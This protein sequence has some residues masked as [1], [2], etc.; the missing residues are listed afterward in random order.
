MKTEGRPP[1]STTREYPDRPIVGVGAV[2]VDQ[3]RVLLVKR[4]S[5]PLLGE[6][7]LPGGVVELGE[8]LRAAAEREAL[9]ETG[10]TVKAGEVL[11]VLDRIIPG[12]DTAPQ[13]HYVLIDFL[14]AVQGGELRAGGDAADVKWA[15]E[16][17]L[18]KFKLERLALDVI[19]KAFLAVNSL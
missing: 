16:S 12:K 13:Y 8:T 1:Q 3:G 17:D 4:G 18:E 6:W 10:L 19:R 9:E 15:S 7:S 5:P 2:I 11:E 14:C